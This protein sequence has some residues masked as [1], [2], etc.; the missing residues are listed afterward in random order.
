MGERLSCN[1]PDLRVRRVNPSCW[2]PPCHRGIPSFNINGQLI[3]A[4]H[5][6]QT[7]SQFTQNGATYLP[8]QTSGN[9]S[10]SHPGSVYLEQLVNGGLYPSNL[11]ILHLPPVT[12][13]DTDMI[14]YEV[15]DDGWE[16]DHGSDNAVNEADVEMDIVVEDE[17]WK[18][19]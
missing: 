10:L 3:P 9:N 4:A 15:E 19:L 1:R 8:A 2:T 13:Y 7:L 11:P 5:L 16:I 6:N 18:T 12:T 14:D 17:G